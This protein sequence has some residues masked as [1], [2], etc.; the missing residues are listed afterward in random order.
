M[1]NITSLQIGQKKIELIKNINSSTVTEMNYTF[2]N[3]KVYK[4][5][6]PFSYH[7]NVNYETEAGWIDNITQIDIPNNARVL[8][9]SLVNNIANRNVYQYNLGCVRIYSSYLSVLPD[10]YYNTGNTDTEWIVTVEYYL[11]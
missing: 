3:K 4:Y 7:L 10:R 8:N 11:P 1:P 6:K 9:I 5:I 2:N